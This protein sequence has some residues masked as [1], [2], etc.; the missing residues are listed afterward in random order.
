MT[1]SSVQNLKEQAKRL[2][3]AIPSVLQQTCTHGQALELIAKQLGSRDWNT[4][5][6]TTRSRTSEKTFSLGQRVSGEYMRQPY[7]AKVIGISQLADANRY[8]VTLQ[9]DHPVDVVTFESFSCFRSRI[10]AVVDRFGI[11]IAR[12]SD[13]NPHL[14]ILAA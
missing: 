6:A 12:T 2:R 8:R 11:S 5:L 4:L 14:K 10:S 3:N 7:S 13:G 9:L 1:I